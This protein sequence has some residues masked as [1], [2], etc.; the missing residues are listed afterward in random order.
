MPTDVGLRRGGEN[1]LDTGV[2]SDLAKVEADEILEANAYQF[3]SKSASERQVIDSQIRQVE[4]QLT[5]FEGSVDLPGLEA[6]REAV[7]KAVA[8]FKDNVY[9]GNVKRPEDVGYDDITV[10]LLSIQN[11]Q[12]HFAG[13]YNNFEQTGLAAGDT[14]DAFPIGVGGD[15]TL[16][17]E[18]VVFFTGD[19]VDL[20]SDA[21]I[22]GLRYENIDGENYNPAQHT[23][24]SERDSDV[25][26]NTVPAALAKSTYD[27]DAY[28][29]HSGDTELV[30]I[31]FQIAKG[32]HVQT[33]L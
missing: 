23:S 18:E 7:I 20:N 12:N 8:W 17:D 4:R 21:I 31:A 16:A 32:E 1:V 22:T 33:T 29:A 10:Q 6:N 19:F 28:A 13:T 27:I 15:G 9:N 14:V 25:Q 3:G 11:I 2:M 24:L 5:G 30:P 26:V